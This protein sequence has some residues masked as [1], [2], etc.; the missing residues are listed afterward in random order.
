MRAYI[1]NVLQPLHNVRPAVYDYLHEPSNW[2]SSQVFGATLRQAGSRGFVYR[3][4]RD[5]GGECLAAFT[6]KAVSIPRQGSHLTYHWDGAAITAVF[7][8][9]RLMWFGHW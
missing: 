6:P 4:V 8:K 7:E 5:P 9:N 3:S 2:D 1:G